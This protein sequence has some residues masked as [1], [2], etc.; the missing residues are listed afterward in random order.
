MAPFL[1]IILIMLGSTIGTIILYQIIIRIVRKFVHFPAPAF[2]GRFLDSDRRRR[3]Q[4]PDAIIMRS[5][6]KSGMK[7]LEIGCGSGAFTTFVARAAGSNGKVY[8]LDIQPG[9]LEQL[10]NK[11][12]KPENKDINN[13]VPK[14]ASAYDLPFSDNSLDL[15]YMVSVFQEI[16]DTVKALE[17]IKR[18]L[19]PG[20]IFAISEFFIDPDYPLRS[21]TVKQGEQAGFKFD[22]VFGNFWN[23]TVRFILQCYSDILPV[24]R[25]KKEARESYDRLSRFYDYTE[26]IFEKKSINIA[27]EHLNIKEGEEVLEIGFGTGNALIKIAKCIG[28]SG[29]AHGVDISPKMLERTNRKINKSGFSDRTELICRDALKLPY[30]DKKFNA[31]FLSFT[32]E[33]FDTPE[34]PK[35]LKEIKRVLKPGGRLGVAGLSKDNGRSLFLRIYEWA[36]TKF[37]RSIDCRP[38]FVAYSLENAGFDIIYRKKAKIFFA[39]L[40]I[41]IGLNK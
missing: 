33:L 27:L 4:S 11:L 23:Y 26:G 18:V 31:V 30:P 36:H 41:V 12:L 6:I 15:V 22:G 17:E 32:L 37:P 29:F 13:I 10:K 25:S 1:K 35:I 28:K 9:M 24:S 34:I 5:G 8:A 7:I 40:E 2:I 39:P 3:I 20:G 16:P 38:I 19:K 14:L 21:T